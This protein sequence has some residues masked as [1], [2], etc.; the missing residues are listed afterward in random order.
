L[1]DRCVPAIT[2]QIDYSYDSS[3]FFSQQ[4][5]RDA[6]Q[7]A[8]TQL[9]N[10]LNDTL[11]QIQPSGQ[12]V[13][14][15]GFTTPG[16]GTALEIDNVTIPNNTILIFAGGRRLSAGTIAIGEAG[17]VTN[18]AGSST[19][20]DTVNARGQVGALASPQ[21]DYGPWG[22]DLVFDSG[23]TNWFFDPDI[24]TIAP[25]QYDFETFA[26]RE[27][28][29]ILGYGV[30]ES[31]TRFATG[32]TFSGPTA[33]A[34][35]GA[36]VPLATDQAH[37]GN[38][39]TIDGVQPTMTGANP[40]ATRLTFT[41]LDQAGLV[42]IGWDINIPAA[43]TVTL[44]VTPATIVEGY[45]VTLTA[46]ATGVSGVVPTGTILFQ[47]NG[48]N[49]GSPITLD[50]NGVATLNSAGF[51]TGSY[52]LT[53]VYSGDANYLPTTGTGTLSVL[54][55]GTV[56]PISPPTL[57]VTPVTPTTPTTPT[58]PTA[59]PTGTVA[60]T[61][62]VSGADLLVISGTGSVSAYVFGTT[63]PV[64]TT[65]TASFRDFVG[66][67]RGAG[68]DVN[69]DGFADL[70]AVTGP[71]ASGLSPLAVQFGNSV[72]SIIDG[73]TGVTI[74]EN[75]PI[76][77]DGYTGGLFVAAGDMNGDG[78]AEIAVSADSGGGGR[79]AIFQLVNGEL[80]RLSDFFGIQDPNF[81]GGSRV[82][83]G[84]VDGDSFGDLIVGAGFG[85][86][87]RV[88]IFSGPSLLQGFSAP[89]KLVPDFFAFGGTD[90]QTLRNGVFVG[91][92][93]MTGDGKA[94]LIVGGGP[95]GGPRVLVISGAVL[96]NTGPNAAISKPVGNFFV[97]DI[98]N[99]RGGVRVSSKDIDNDG[100]D[101]IVVGSG[102][103]EANTVRYYNSR[104]LKASGEPFLSGLLSP[105]G[106]NELAGV[107]VG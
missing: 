94:D 46:T 93:D 106:A 30:A 65:L 5:R 4:T 10:F 98:D 86:G 66:Q 43:P 7:R 40:L 100:R 63:R 36:R 38:T 32:G 1:E 54:A 69:G 49:L 97:D 75:V 82:A 101:D 50:S 77:E 55:F 95:G 79:V 34:Q 73:A 42:D 68:A 92:G 57:P 80:I 31:W 103:G 44:T 14:T 20:I 76:F 83:I 62:V 47:S 99:S 96:L 72:L 11:T 107:F 9:G 64:V 89:P 91:A 13:W 58:A 24:S 41:R 33:Q 85:G 61:G 45:T 21:T 78:K 29:L 67:A 102:D 104:N 105:G 22:G 70:I 27:L 19:F 18:V 60:P 2:F 59:P 6:L 71:P 37:W 84:D 74:L 56:P 51:T 90:V 8:A 35:F 15:L 26:T 16:S 81:R 23:S 52:S 48:T 3:N 53:A 25:N 39:V 88:A 12:D 87:P 28:C 17:T